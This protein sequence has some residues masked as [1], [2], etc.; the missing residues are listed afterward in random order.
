MNRSRLFLLSLCTMLLAVMALSASAA[1]AEPNA[2]WLILDEDGTALDANDLHAAIE[3][4]LENNHLILLTEI[5][6]LKVEILCTAIQLI[7]GAIL[8]QGSVVGTVKLTGC[9][10]VISG[11]ESKPCVPHTK[12]APAGTLESTHGHG[13]IVLHELS[14]TVRDELVLLLPETGNTIFTL[15]MGEACALGESL[16]I[17]GKFV[18]KDC[19][20]AFLTHQVIHLIE[21]GPLS[22]LFIISDTPEHAVKVDGSVNVFLSGT[23]LNRPWS[24]MAG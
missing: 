18:V 14:P 21:E 9:K 5:L 24:G 16:P 1:Q 6:K 3:G 23:H 2:K 11:K 13:L 22:H 7:G 15:E 12:G 10:I 19:Q 8:G 20:N 17:K 4:T